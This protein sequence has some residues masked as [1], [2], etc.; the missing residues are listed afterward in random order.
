MTYRVI[1]SVR[2]HYPLSEIILSTWKGSGGDRLGADVLIENDDP[3]AVPINPDCPNLRGTLNNMNRQI[4]STRAGLSKA[5]R[6]YAIKMRTDT[7][8][9][10]PLDIESVVGRS[11]IGNAAVFS[12]RVGV[13]NLYTRHPERRPILFFLSDLFHVGLLADLQLLWDVTP[14]EE[15]G[16]TRTI[17]PLRRP[18]INVLNPGLFLFRTSPEQYLGECL[19]RRLQPSLRLRHYSDG[20]NEWL[21][22]WLSVLASNFTILRPQAAG[23]V[24]PHYIAEHGDAG[25]LVQPEDWKTLRHWSEARPS[26]SVRMGSQFRFN[27][28][29]FRYA[30]AEVIRRM[31]LPIA[32]AIHYAYSLVR[33]KT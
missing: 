25:D 8:I 4:V 19:C 27:L 5:T 29:R 22:L 1:Q 32:W 28:N 26:F 17:D 6:R 30:R 20:S 33:K 24:L 10:S 11:P 3:G 15:P 16:F 12:K 14:V 2:R 9:E 21:Y 31:P 18:W 23:L 13:L 7:L